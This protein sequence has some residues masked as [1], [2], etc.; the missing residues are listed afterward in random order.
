MKNLLNE[1]PSPYASLCGRQK[2]SCDFVSDEHLRNKKVLNIGC[3]IGWFELFCVTK[4]VAVVHAVEIDE[5]GIS[6]ARSNVRYSNVEFSVGNA[7]SLP[8]SDGLFDTIVCWEVLEHIPTNTEPL[9]FSEIFRMLKP[10]GQFYMSTPYRSILSTLLDPAWWLIG[11]RHYM[12][13]QLEELAETAGLK[14]RRLEKKG[15]I[16]EII[17]WWNLYISK[18]I[19]R[20]HPFYEKYMKD[21]AI[22]EFCGDKDGFTNIFVHLEKPM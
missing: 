13:G 15:R 17:G 16:W 21:K 19:F 11:H 14:I 18:W 6:T 5:E 8:F 7:L 2:F 22:R 12:E 4:Y 9:M 1:K 3:G 10:S 20:R